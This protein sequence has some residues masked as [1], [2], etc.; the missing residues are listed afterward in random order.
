MKCTSSSFYLH[1]FLLFILN[2]PQLYRCHLGINKTAS[3]PSHYL[4]TELLCIYNMFLRETSFCVCSALNWGMCI[5][6][7]VICPVF[8]ALQRVKLLLS[9][10][11]GSLKQ[12]FPLHQAQRIGKDMQFKQNSSLVLVSALATSQTFSYLVLSD[13]FFHFWGLSQKHF[14]QNWS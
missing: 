2:P 6:H 11:L 9:E 8:V 13:N 12:V 1:T 4:L 3:L 5:F 7:L 14:R 10:L